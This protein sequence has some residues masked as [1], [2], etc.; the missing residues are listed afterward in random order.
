MFRQKFTGVCVV[1]VP[2]PVP[3]LAAVP[4]PH[5]TLAFLGRVSGFRPADFEYMR[6][7]LGSYVLTA[8][9]IEA[10]VNGFG[11]FLSPS[12]LVPVWLLDSPRI[13]GDRAR[14]WELLRH[15]RRSEVEHGFIPHITVPESTG[16]DEPFPVRLARLE[17]W[18][19][20]ERT[21]WPVGRAG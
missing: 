5:V 14:V 20:K 21:S 11:S 15:Y 19:G 16:L 7:L 12:G 17:F 18:A 4:D 13:Q 9:A 6:R 1:M 3:Q 2:D 8:P 10:T